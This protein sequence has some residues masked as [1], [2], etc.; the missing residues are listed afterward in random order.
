MKLKD[1]LKPEE[2]HG[3]TPEAYSRAYEQ[4]WRHY[5]RAGT[6]GI[7]ENP[8]GYGAGLGDAWEDG[9]LDRA[10]RGE[11]KWITP[12]LGYERATSEGGVVFSE[13]LRA[14]WK[15]AREGL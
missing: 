6:Y 4:G 8:Y 11:C 14:E 10:N 3:L 15:A 12:L 5:W 7:D 13:E 2:L 1:L 9:Y